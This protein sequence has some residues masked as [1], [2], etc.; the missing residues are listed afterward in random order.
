MWRVE[1]FTGRNTAYDACF[2]GQGAAWPCAAVSV[3]QYCHARGRYANHYRLK[4]CRC[5]SR[6]RLVPGGVVLLA[7]QPGI[8]KSTLLLQIANLV[9]KK[10]AVLYVS[11]E[12]SERQI[13]LR[14]ARLG[15]ANEQLQLA[16][17]PVADDAAA[18]IASGEYS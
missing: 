1:H 12:E 14:A 4:R 8:G 6:W 15:A 13:G 11:G 3:G 7:G 18:S 16:T 10:H 2:G 17:A 5:S 9:A